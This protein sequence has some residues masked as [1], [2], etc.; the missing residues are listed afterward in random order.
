MLFDLSSAHSNPHNPIPHSLLQYRF[1]LIIVAASPLASAAH[2]AAAHQ[3]LPARRSRSRKHKQLIRTMS[4]ARRTF[5][6]AA[7]LLLGLASAQVRVGW[8]G[9]SSW[10]GSTKG[11]TPPCDTPPCGPKAAVFVRSARAPLGL[12][13]ALENVPNVSMPCVCEKTFMRGIRLELVYV[14]FVFR[15][16]APSPP[17]LLPAPPLPSS[18]RHPIWPE[19]LLTHSAQK[20]GTRNF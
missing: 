3:S 17:P 2:V 12:Q 13:T 16:M 6:A 20:H 8:S 18:L 11:D 7:L 5:T 14:L 1:R 19:S 15:V 10:E 4:H 9:W